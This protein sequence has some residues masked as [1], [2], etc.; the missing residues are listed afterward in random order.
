MNSFEWDKTVQ[1]VHHRANVTTSDCLFG[2]RRFNQLYKDKKTENLLN[3]QLLQQQKISH[4]CI[5]IDGGRLRLSNFQNKCE[6]F[7]VVPTNSSSNK[8]LQN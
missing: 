4:I 1:S 3:L 2:L 8:L 6:L 5:Y 7:S